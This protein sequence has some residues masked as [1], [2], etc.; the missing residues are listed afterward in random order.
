MPQLTRRQ[1]AAAAAAIALGAGR[2]LSQQPALTD[3][4]ASFTLDQLMNIFTKTAGGTQYWADVW[5]L[6]QW[7]IQR[8]VFTGRYRLLD[9][10][11]H[12]HASGTLDECRQEVDTIRTRENLPPMQGKAVI[13]LHGLFRTRSGM[14]SLCDSL[15]KDGGHSTFNVGYPTTRG[16]VA[17]HAASLDS[18]VQSLAGVT[19]LNFVG[20]SLGSLVVR[21]WL[22]ELLAGDRKLLAGQQLG[23]MVMLAPP[24]QHPQI[25]TALIRGELAQAV[26]GAAATE[27]ATGWDTLA[28]KLATPPFD[29]GIL[30]GGRGDGRGFN[31][32][33]AGDDDAV[34]TVECRASPAHAIFACC[35]FSTALSCW[36]P[37]SKN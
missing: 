25:A 26:A 9:R 35:R 29:F 36:T 20:H 37:A 30:A 34:I 14:Q 21:H 23:R 15:E 19:E 4:N 6:H 31:P 27:L 32:L 13:V 22:G 3:P 12:R 10:D 16:S 1:F 2:A 8:N 18:V 24:N 5:F 7:R 28:P 11:N 33:L 17:E